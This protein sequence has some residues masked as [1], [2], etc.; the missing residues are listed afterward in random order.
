MFD[1]QNNSFKNSLTIELNLSNSHYHSNI[2]KSL[3]NKIRDTEDSF[4]LD[5]LSFNKFFL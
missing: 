5:N 1:R 2:N 4:S 3:S